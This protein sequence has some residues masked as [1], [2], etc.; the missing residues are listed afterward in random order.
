MQK[1]KPGLDAVGFDFGTTNSA[2]AVLDQEREVQL[3]SFPSLSGP[4]EAV[5]S[6][7]YIESLRAESGARKAHALVGSAAIERY[8]QAEA[9]IAPP[10]ASEVVIQTMPEAQPS[11]V[12]ELAAA[13]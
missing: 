11:G 12:P 4:I 8:L 7:L 13:G 5:R 6:V 2:I 9:A 10:A 1:T 3:A